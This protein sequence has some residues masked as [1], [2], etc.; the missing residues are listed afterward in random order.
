MKSNS[1]PWTLRE[2]GLPSGL[3]RLPQEAI[4]IRVWELYLIRNRTNLTNILASY[5][6]DNIGTPFKA[7]SPE[8]VSF[9]FLTYDWE[10][11]I[12][13]LLNHHHVP[14]EVVANLS[15]DLYDSKLKKKVYVVE[16]DLSL[17]FA[18]NTMLE[19]AGYDVI[20]SHCGN[21]MMQKHLPKTDLIV[22]DRRMPDVDGIE[23]CRHLRAQA[24]TAA[25]PIIM[26]SAHH[27]FIRDAYNAGVNDCLAKPFDM[28]EL[29]KLV[30]KHTAKER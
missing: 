29:L 12:K 22:L 19:G 25:T 27:N 13:K 2:K 14:F 4:E 8:K 30:S 26:I 21:P 17:L 20:L 10:R 15:I 24:D 9:R 28:Q 23:I 11:S 6:L 7:D 16:D 5:S 1:T 3:K 18:L